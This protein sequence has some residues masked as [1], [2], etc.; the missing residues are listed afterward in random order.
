MKKKTT[1]PSPGTLQRFA[2]LATLLTA[3]SSPALAQIGIET[4]PNADRICA[5]MQCIFMPV[6]VDYFMTGPSKPDAHVVQV[7]FG[8]DFPTG[9]D[10]FLYR[11]TDAT[12]WAYTTGKTW[13]LLGPP[14]QSQMH[15][16]ATSASVVRLGRTA[17]GERLG[18]Q[19]YPLRVLTR[20]EELQQQQQPQQQQQA[21]SDDGW[22]WAILGGL[23]LWGLSEAALANEKSEQDECVRKCTLERA[24]CV[25]LCTMEK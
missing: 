18:H 2:I 4:D 5:E 23:A 25:E 7:F 6:D 24:R 14:L 9:I 3:I 16:R 8:K 21:S 11:E 22:G 15:I 20:Q 10:S 17:N 13:R 12:L 1:S 19:D